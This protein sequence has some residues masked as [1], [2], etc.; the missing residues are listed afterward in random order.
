[1]DDRAAGLHDIAPSS[2]H[3]HTHQTHPAIHAFSAKPISGVFPLKVGLDH[4]S[5]SHQSAITPAQNKCRSLLALAKC[6]GVCIMASKCD[7]AS[8]SPAHCTGVYEG[9]PCQWG[10]FDSTSNAGKEA[11]QMWQTVCANLGKGLFSYG[12]SPQEGSAQGD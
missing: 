1:M 4:H 12:A 3:Q 11:L 2:C 9:F 8:S 6:A 5:T 7:S 10:A